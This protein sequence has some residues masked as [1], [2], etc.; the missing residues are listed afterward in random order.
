VAKWYNQSLFIFP[1]FEVQ[2]IKQNNIVLVQIMKPEF[3]K[4]DLALLNKPR[5]LNTIEILVKKLQ[6]SDF[7]LFQE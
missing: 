1:L 7:F 5:N 3:I 4:L 2:K 6:T